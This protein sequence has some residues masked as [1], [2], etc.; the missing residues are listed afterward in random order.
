MGFQCQQFY[1]KDDQCA[2]KVSTDSLLLGSYVP[3][4]GVKR[5]LDMGTGS[6]LLA[7]MAA[8]RAP[9]AQVDGFDADAAAVAQAQDNAMHSPWPDRIHLSQCCVTSWQP[10]QRYDVVLCNPP[11]FTNHLSSRDSARE[12]A[13]Q[14]VVAP[15]QWLLCALRSLHASGALYWVLPT[16]QAAAW[17]TLAEAHGLHLKTELSIQTTVNKPVKLVIQ[18]WQLAPVA[19]VAKEALTIHDQSGAYSEAFRKLTGEF[20]LAGRNI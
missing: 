5:V 15:Q 18:G 20:Y 8:Q 7:L 1:I 14:G 11:Y 19:A 16:S 9:Q 13:R 3:V 4:G 6:G 10:E 17:Q 12:S 2:M